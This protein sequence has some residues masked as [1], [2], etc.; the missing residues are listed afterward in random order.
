MDLTKNFNNS[1]FSASFFF[2]YPFSKMGFF[3]VDIDYGEKEKWFNFF[4]LLDGILLNN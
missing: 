3:S 4:D 1:S 2:K